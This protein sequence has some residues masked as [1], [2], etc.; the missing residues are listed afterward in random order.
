MRGGS[1]EDTLHGNAGW[2]SLWGG[3]DNDTLFG[4]AGRDYLS[5]QDG[6][7]YLEGGYGDGLDRLRG[8][9]GSDTFVEYW[10]E[11]YY[12]RSG[13]HPESVSEADDVLDL[14]DGDRIERSY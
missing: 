13:H 3:S 4:D 2:D 11:A 6:D 10:R 8:G 12:D 1:G 14:S 5:G 9:T 7:D